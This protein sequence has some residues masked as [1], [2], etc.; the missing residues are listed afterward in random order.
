MSEKLICQNKKAWHNY[1]IETARN[2]KV[3]TTNYDTVS[4]GRGTTILTLIFEL[5]ALSLELQT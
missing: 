5:T 4:Q 2:L 1:F 3:A